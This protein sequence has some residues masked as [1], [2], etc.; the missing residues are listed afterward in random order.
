MENA[1]NSLLPMI[2]YKILQVLSAA[3]GIASHK[4]RRPIVLQFRKA[5]KEVCMLDEL[6]WNTF[7]CNV[8]GYDG[9]GFLVLFRPRL[10]A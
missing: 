1:S 4:D 2:C 5:S 3:C 10:S 7:G 6:S 8:E 9:V